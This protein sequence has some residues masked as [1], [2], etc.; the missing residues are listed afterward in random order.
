MSSMCR[1]ECE[2][3]REGIHFVAIRQVRYDK[4][5]GSCIKCQKAWTT[6]QRYCHCCKSKMRY[7]R[8]DKN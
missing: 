1:G 2:T 6:N 7:N 3:N 4:G 8:R 5:M